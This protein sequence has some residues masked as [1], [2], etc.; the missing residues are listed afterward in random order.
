MYVNFSWNVCVYSSNF[1]CMYLCTS[2]IDIHN[3]DHILSSLHLAA[4][5]L[6]WLIWSIVQLSLC[7]CVIALS[8]SLLVPLFYVWYSWSYGWS[9][10]LN[11]SHVGAQTSHISTKY[12]AYIC[13]L[14][15]IFV[16]GTYMTIT[17][18]VDVAVSYDLTCIHQFGVCIPV[19]DL[20]IPL[21]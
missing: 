7:N 20:L 1:T 5:Y 19:Y 3:M 6:L 16:C 17:C 14:V 11:I 21:G 2:C 13:S 8:S 4:T 10:W 12:M 9:Q 18:E 15:G